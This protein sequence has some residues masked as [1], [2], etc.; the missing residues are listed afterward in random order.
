M[1]NTPL[2]GMEHQYGLCIVGDTPR[3][4]KVTG[5]TA[6]SGKISAAKRTVT[7]RYGFHGEVR[8]SPSGRVLARR[9]CRVG[10]AVLYP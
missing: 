3:P 4:V 10:L 5:K 7:A 8:E 2:G 9:P 1:A 6:Q